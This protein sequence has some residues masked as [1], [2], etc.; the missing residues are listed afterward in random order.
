MQGL[1]QHLEIYYILLRTVNSKRQRKL[2]RDVLYKLKY[3]NS[4]KVSCWFLVHLPN[5]QVFP[6]NNIFKI[7]Y[8]S[9]KVGGQ[10]LGQEHFWGAVASLPPTSRRTATAS[11]KSISYPRYLTWTTLNALWRNDPLF[12]KRV[13]IYRN[14]FL[15]HFCQD[16][17]TVWSLSQNN[18]RIPACHISAL[19]SLWCS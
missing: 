12:H 13:I 4:L 2:D 8:Y 3:S 6:L 15:Q 1:H 16:R 5:S 11:K 17:K 14:R 9:R 7:L 10:R 18:I 19:W